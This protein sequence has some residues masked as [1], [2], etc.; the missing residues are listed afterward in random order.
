MNMI[1]MLHKSNTA[2]IFTKYTS[3]EGKNANL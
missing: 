2:K 3:R 1:W